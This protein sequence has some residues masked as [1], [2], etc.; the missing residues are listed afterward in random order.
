[1]FFKYNLCL[2]E[3][4]FDELIKSLDFNEKQLDSC[5]AKKLKGG[6]INGAK[7]GK[8]GIIEISLSDKI[9][10]ELIFQLLRTNNYLLT[11]LNYNN[12]NKKRNDEL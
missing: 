2:Y 12:I 11:E 10:Q 4:S 6:F 1:M 9:L 5:I 3:N 8:N 7:Q